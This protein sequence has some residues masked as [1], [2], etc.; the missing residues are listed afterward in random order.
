MSSFLW[1]MLVSDAAV[2][3]NPKTSGSP[4]VPLIDQVS[5]AGS[6][7]RRQDVG[8]ARLK[9]ISSTR[10]G[11]FTLIKAAIEATGQDGGYRC[12]LI[13]TSASACQL[14][15]KRLVL[16]S[17]GQLLWHLLPSEQKGSVNI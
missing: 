16:L 10:T 4:G 9:L 12:A 1:L 17:A 8:Q 5:A 13:A 3:S 14:L 11:P 15:H 7:G 6:P 2:G